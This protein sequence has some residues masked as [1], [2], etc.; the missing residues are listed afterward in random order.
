MGVILKDS[1]LNFIFQK[2]SVSL[3][4]ILILI[5]EKSKIFLNLSNFENIMKIFKLGI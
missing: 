1:Q 3:L 2:N 5:T 4:F